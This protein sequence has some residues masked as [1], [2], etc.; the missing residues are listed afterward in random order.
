MAVV[1]VAGAS[2]GIGAAVA[3]AL[4]TPDHHLVLAARDAA[5]L[6]AVA[7]QVR[8]AGG[9]AT[10]VACDLTAEPHVCRLI[11]QARA[12]SGQIDGLVHAAGRALVAPLHEIT[13][14]DWEGLLRV[15]LTSTFLLCKHVRPH[16]PAGSCIVTIASVAAK[17][18]FPG[19]A[20]YS[21]S[22]AGVLALTN[23][24]REELRPAG[25]RVVAVLP[26][27]TDTGLWDS[28]PGEW[29]RNNMIQAADVGRSVAWVL[30]QPPE[31]TIEELTIGHVI[32]RL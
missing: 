21:A 14:A 4:A 8:A 7:A 19:W 29:N 24:L 23:A 2:R 5:A 32:G 9:A 18:A 25:V 1:I 22:K 26:A 13:L 27:A 10:T 20:A 16:M 11:E 6:E 17:Q 15:N 30:A 12:I 31:V 3:Q 28:V